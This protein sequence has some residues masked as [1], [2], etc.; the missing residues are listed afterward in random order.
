MGNYPTPTALDQD[1]F[2]FF[3][4]WYDFSFLNLLLLLGCTG[5]SLQH[6]LA[7][8]A[9]HRHNCSEACGILVPWLGIKPTFP[10]LEGRFL[11][12]GQP[13][14]SLDQDFLTSAWFGLDNFVQGA[15]LY[16]ARCLAAVLI[17]W[18]PAALNKLT[19]KNC[20]QILPKVSWEQN[21][22]PAPNLRWDPLL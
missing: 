9:A 6:G 11:T 12:T 14:K 7:L 22:P 1:F 2:F 3:Y 5:S 18:M 8:V 13:K 4:S 16:T 10:A 20:P 21:H 17:H 15:A 19:K